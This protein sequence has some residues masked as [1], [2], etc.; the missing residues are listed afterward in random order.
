MP[1]SLLLHRDP[2][3]QPGTFLAS[4]NNMLDMPFQP[5]LDVCITA[6][7]VDSGE[8]LRVRHLLKAQWM[9]TLSAFKQ[10]SEANATSIGIPLGVYTCL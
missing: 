6:L 8:A 9:N 2:I 4:S 5:A 7:A 10:L 3:I 1:V